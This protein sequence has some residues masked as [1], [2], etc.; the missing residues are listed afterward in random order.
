MKMRKLAFSLLFSLASITGFSQKIYFVYLQSEG[1]Q[2]FYVNI[3][4]GIHSS[5]AAG[6]I[7]LPKLLDSTYNFA[8]GFP[9]NQWPEQNFSITMNKKDHGFLLKNFGEKGWG[10]FD[11]QTLTVQM[12]VSGSARTEEK[13]MEE[14]KDVSV[15]TE[16]LSKVTDDPSLKEKTAKSGIEEKNAEPLIQENTSIVN[17]EKVIKELTA[18]KPVE[19]TEQPEVKKEEPKSGIPEQPAANV[20]EIETPVEEQYKPTVVTK[21]SESSTTEGFGLVFIDDLGKGI[22]DTIRLLIPNSKSVV[23]EITGEPEKEKKF[24]DILPDTVKKKEEKVAE[25]IPVVT[26]NPVEKGVVKNNCPAVAEESD[27]FKL[28]KNMAAAEGDDNMLTEAKNYFKTKCF[29]TEQ[30]KNLG[31]LFL[32]DEGKY[33]FFDLAYLYVT[34]MD[35]FSVL[36]NELKEVYFINRFKAM[37]PN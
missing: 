20:Q 30:V 18:V 28:R 11:L 9:K 2:P 17:T 3:N 24:L 32:N 29:T 10:L 7:I 13:N 19:I 37:L 27:F 12:A 4:A 21:R 8:V 33:K 22:N 14:N 15:F 36:Q 23:K 26:E 1:G 34:D 16:L 31:L 6:Y 5:S 25:G 35:K